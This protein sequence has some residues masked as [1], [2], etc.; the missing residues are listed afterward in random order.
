[1]I[2]PEAK[3]KIL[4]FLS[5]DVYLNDIMAKGMNS[6]LSYLEVF[7]QSSSVVAVLTEEYVE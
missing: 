5:I 3:S 7:D 2:P 4:I 1:M 6:G